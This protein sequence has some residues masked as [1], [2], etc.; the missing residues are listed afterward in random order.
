MVVYSKRTIDYIELQSMVQ[1]LTVVES[2][3]LTDPSQEEYLIPTHKYTHNTT[4]ACEVNG[5]RERERDRQTDRQRE[6][7]RERER[8]QV[9]RGE[10]MNT[11]LVVALLTA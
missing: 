11:S 7:E 8:K 3:L 5:M 6:R 2:F 9:K 1:T 10:Q 4:R